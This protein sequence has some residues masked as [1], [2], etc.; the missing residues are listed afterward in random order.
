VNLVLTGGGTGGHITPT[1]AVAHELKRQQPDC[2]ITYIIERRGKFANLVTA[3]TAI[4]NVHFIFAGKLRRYHGESWLRRLTDVKTICLNLR[5]VVYLAIGFSQSLWLMGHLKPDVVFVKGGYV[6][7]P[8]GAAAAFWRRN[9]VTHDSDTMPGLTNRIVARWA[10]IMATAYPAKFYSYPQSKVRHVGVPVA[11]SFSLVTDRQKQALRKRIGVPIRAATILITGGSLGAVRLNQTVA[12]MVPELLNRN[13]GV[14]VIH[15]T[16]AKSK[17]VYGSHPPKKVIV[18]EFLQ[19]LSDYSGAADIVIAR[20]GA[21]TMAEVAAQGKACIVVPSPFL[22]DGHQL[23]NAAHLA[24]QGAAVDVEEGKGL[25]DRLL[26]AVQELLDKPD[27]AEL[28]AKTLH[29]LLRPDA[30]HELAVLLL[31]EA[32]K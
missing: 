8:V 24:E 10:R 14:F 9:I 25:P 26:N 11:D 20:P 13:E 19:P 12:S 23:K 7:L 17:N 5:D 22:A 18:R 3:D 2:T 28:L 15:Q 1:L 4:D 32:K 16:G 29:R 30:A 31:E 6:G 21:T 27:K